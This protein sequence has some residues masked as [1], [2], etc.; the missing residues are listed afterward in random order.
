MARKYIN[1][2]KRT[3]YYK[4]LAKKLE[5]MADNPGLISSD[6]ELGPKLKINPKSSFFIQFNEPQNNLPLML[7]GTT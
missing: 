7:E 3:F 1:I 4:D 6:P 2:L 5:S